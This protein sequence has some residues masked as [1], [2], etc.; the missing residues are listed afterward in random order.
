MSKFSQINHENQFGLDH[1]CHKRFLCIS[2]VNMMLIIARNC[3]ERAGMVEEG[4]KV[5]CT[6]SSSTYRLADSSLP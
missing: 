3:M 2:A 1:C 5:V 6:S 4:C